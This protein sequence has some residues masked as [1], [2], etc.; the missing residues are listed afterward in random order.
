MGPCHGPRHA[1][2]A[3]PT[4]RSD[5]LYRRWAAI[6]LHVLR[7]RRLQRRH[8]SADQQR[9]PGAVPNHYRGQ[10]VAQS[11]GTVSAVHLRAQPLPADVLPWCHL[12]CCR[13]AARAERGVLLLRL[14]RGRDSGDGTDVIHDPRGYAAHDGVRHCHTE[15]YR[16]ARVYRLVRRSGVCGWRYCIVPAGQLI[17]GHTGA[18]LR[19]VHV[20]AAAAHCLQRRAQQL[21]FIVVQRRSPS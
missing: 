1:Q 9:Q 18:G 17:P 3:W 4:G 20:S 19:L 13:R 21:V 6:R 16:H 5:S 10:W 8:N 12:L 2:P 11:S 14:L 7:R 15:Q